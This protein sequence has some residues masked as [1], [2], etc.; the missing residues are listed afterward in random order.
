MFS[1][2][3]CWT[4]SAWLWRRD[5][6]RLKNLILGLIRRSWY[7]SND[8][9]VI[10]CMILEEAVLKK[11]GGPRHVMVEREGGLIRFHP[12]KIGEDWVK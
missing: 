1:K 10:F 4:K 5:K 9:F 11:Q 8:L 3:D 12:Y 6:D 2:G 7:I